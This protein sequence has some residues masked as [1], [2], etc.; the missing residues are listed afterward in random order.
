MKKLPI[1]NKHL[2]IF[3]HKSSLSKGFF[4]REVNETRTEQVYFGVATDLNSKGYLYA[5]LIHALWDDVNDIEGIQIIFNDDQYDF[6][7]D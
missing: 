7:L 2:F 5:A 1:T 3:K 6:K 4:I